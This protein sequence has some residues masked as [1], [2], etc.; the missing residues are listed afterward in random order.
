MNR[1]KPLVALC[2]LMFALAD[3]SVAQT[4]VTQLPQTC[5]A[6]VQY[7]LSP[8]AGPYAGL[9][10]G[11]YNCLPG[12]VLAQFGGGG[13][14]TLLLLSD[15]TN[16]TATPATVFSFPVLANTNYTFACTMFWQ[17]SG[18]NTETFT[19][20]TPSSPTSVLAFGQVIYNA[21]G[22][23]NTAPLSGSPLAITSTAAGAGSTTYKASI[24]GGIQNVTAGTLAFQISAGT[25][26]ST[27]KANSFCTAR[28]AP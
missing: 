27:V 12:N 19:L 3:L 15:F 14:N 2:A 1:L 6:G 13:A 23:Q 8:P 5:T 21:A 7:F 10:A 28:S 26:T 20:T 18:T 25:G 22:A 17:N 24:E 16:T 4:Q 9:T 11:I